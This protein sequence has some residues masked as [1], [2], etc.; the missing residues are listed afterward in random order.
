[1]R[2]KVLFIVP[3]TACSFLVLGVLESFVGFISESHLHFIH[4]S[5]SGLPPLLRKNLKKE[6]KKQR[7][8]FILKAT[9]GANAIISK[10][11]FIF[12]FKAE[13]EL[14]VSSLA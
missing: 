14:K 8:T 7:L 13:N 10:F 3:Q 4:I 5:K 11:T 12:S 9:L 2:F 1:M 6:N